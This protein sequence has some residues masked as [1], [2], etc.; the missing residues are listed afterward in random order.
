MINLVLEFTKKILSNNLY[1]KD[2]EFINELFKINLFRNKVICIFFILVEFIIFSIYLLTSKKD[3]LGF[4]NISSHM[5]FHIVMFLVSLIWLIIFKKIETYH[6]V[7]KKLISILQFT[8]ISYILL[9]GGT[10]S[11]IDQ[12]S[13]GQI[14]V[15][16]VSAMSM[17]VMP[18]LKPKCSFGIYMYIHILFIIF[19]LLFQKSMLLL[20][21][22]VFYSSIFV[23]LSWIISIILF[24][25][26]LNDF[27]NRKLIQQKNIELS[28]MNNELMKI[29]SNLEELS[30]T[31]CLTGIANRRKF[32]SFI[33][34]EWN[35][36]KNNFIPLSAIMID[37][38]FFKLFNDNYGH[39]TGDYCLKKIGET[40]STSLSNKNGIVA[41]YGG[42]EF[43]IVIE[44]LTKESALI[45]AEKIRKNIEDLNIPHNFS[46][47]SNCVTISLGVS[48]LIPSNNSSIKTLIEK[49]DIALY[50]AKKRNR[51]K[52][53]I[54]E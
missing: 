30:C 22:N 41:R 49:A 53:I 11:I 46:P 39:Q 29:N 43:I 9:W 10:I 27:K 4:I 3:F 5:Y 54:Y 18:Y 50:K 26:K 36:C 33:K 2:E 8:F 35:K 1:S 51:N 47:V 6:N 17:A 14:T 37:V 15:Y 13:T 20:F 19:L 7:N 24:N 31:D 16:S 45:E 12:M 48:S 38:D 25:N 42:E 34:F 23:T 32:E 21:I 28:R 52:T 44:G 40:L